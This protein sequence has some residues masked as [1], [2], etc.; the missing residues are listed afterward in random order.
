M[1]QEINMSGG[2]SNPV[3][4]NSIH[5]DGM[6]LDLKIKEQLKWKL[7]EFGAKQKAKDDRLM[8]LEVSFNR[9]DQTYKDAIQAV[10]DASQIEFENLK[11]Q[12]IQI[13][14]RMLN[15]ERNINIMAETM[16]Q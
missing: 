10:S 16:T 9:S 7:D 2:N 5:N 4:L 14:E 1:K 3:I 6:A 8:A 15:H 12:Y 11:G 13:N